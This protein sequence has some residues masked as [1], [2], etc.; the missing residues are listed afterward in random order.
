MYNFSSYLEKLPPP[1]DFAFE[2][3]AGFIPSSRDEVS[4]FP[5]LLQSLNWAMNLVLRYTSSSH[6]MHFEQD[7]RTIA[8]REGRTFAGSTSSLSGLLS[9]IY[10]LISSDK[11][12]NTTSL[13]RHFQYEVMPSFVTSH[14]CMLIF[15]FLCS[16]PPL[17]RVSVCQLVLCSTTLTVSTQ[18]TLI[19]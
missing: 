11:D 13:S 14:R 3:L 8:T 15:Q 6:N 17:R 18:S 10:F 16:Q 1:Q 7:L 19:S 2:R 4:L 5:S 12:V 9:H